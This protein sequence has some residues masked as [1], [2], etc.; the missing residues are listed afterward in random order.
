MLGVDFGITKKR[1]ERESSLDAGER[2]IITSADTGS[3][4]FAVRYRRRSSLGAGCGIERLPQ[5]P[6]AELVPRAKK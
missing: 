4:V 6:R 5:P 2:E 3:R 1:V